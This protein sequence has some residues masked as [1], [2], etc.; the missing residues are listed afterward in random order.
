MGIENMKISKIMTNLYKGLTE[1]EIIER[2]DYHNIKY[3]LEFSASNE[4]S[5]IIYDKYIV[6]CN[7][8]ICYEVLTK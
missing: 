5:K 1:N 4:V 8:N 3:T 2:L 7:K 6:K